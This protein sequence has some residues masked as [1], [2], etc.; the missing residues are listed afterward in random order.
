MGTTVE[1]LTS[2]SK[3]IDLLIAEEENDMLVL[4]SPLLQNLV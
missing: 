4:Y 2:L 1:Q 3:W